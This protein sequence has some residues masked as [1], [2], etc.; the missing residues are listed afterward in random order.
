MIFSAE[1]VA[2][3]LGQSLNGIAIDM[4]KA[5]HSVVRN[6]HFVGGLVRRDALEDRIKELLSNSSFNGIRSM[7]QLLVSYLLGQ[8]CFFY[9]ILALHYG[10]S[11]LLTP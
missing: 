11:P 7:M 5:P 3:I 4:K 1:D 10:S 6:T 8:F 2:L 9:R